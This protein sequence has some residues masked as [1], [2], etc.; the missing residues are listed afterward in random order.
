[1]RI[2]FDINHRAKIESGEY[3]VKTKKGDSV[4]II[5]WPNPQTGQNKIVAKVGEEGLVWYDTTGKNVDLK[6]EYDLV[7]VA[8]GPK[9]TDFEK[10]MIDY[11]RDII[12]C[13]NDEDVDDVTRRHS[14]KLINIARDVL[15]VNA[16]HWITT[17]IDIQSNSLDFIVKFVDNKGNTVIVPTNRVL[18]G[19]EFMEIRSVYSFLK[20]I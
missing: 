14:S 4:N 6:P 12:D 2:P 17:Q 16:P 10:G 11:V 13:R 8:Q 3:I 15:L 9:L 5:L 19:E 1:M 7:L 18:A 20:G